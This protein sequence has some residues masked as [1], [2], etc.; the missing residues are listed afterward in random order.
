MLVP[1][2]PGLMKQVSFV[3]EVI[4]MATMEGSSSNGI[5]RFWL[6]MAIVYFT[7]QS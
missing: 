7:W 4:M 6:I 3:M 2:I 1:M 5:L